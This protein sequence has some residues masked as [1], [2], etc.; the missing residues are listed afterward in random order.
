ML[1]YTYFDVT[2]DHYRDFENSYQWV[3]FWSRILLPP[4]P[5]VYIVR[6]NNVALY[7]GQAKSIQGRW[8]SHSMIRTIKDFD[9]IYPD[10]ELV[11]G[12]IEIADKRKRSLIET[13]LIAEVHT[14]FNQEMGLSPL[15]NGLRKELRQKLSKAITKP[16]RPKQRRVNPESQERV[17]SVLE[18]IYSLV[19]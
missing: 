7:I 12:W 11:I 9:K 4:T 19:R 8:Q 14:V 3:S 6:Y 18:E 17:N 5:G 2:P 10:G 13:C 15:F 1:L 16:D